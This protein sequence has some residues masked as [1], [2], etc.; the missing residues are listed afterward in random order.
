MTGYDAAPHPPATPV[1]HTRDALPTSRF[2]R[3][4]KYKLFIAEM[5]QLLWSRGDRSR[6]DFKSKYCKFL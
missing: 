6:K 4:A 3:K 1:R 2:L 5:G